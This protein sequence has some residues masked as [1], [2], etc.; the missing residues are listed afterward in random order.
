MCSWRQKIESYCENLACEPTAEV[1]KKRAKHSI[2]VE[3]V[4]GLAEERKLVQLSLN[5]NC[6]PQ[7][8]ARLSRYI[9]TTGKALDQDFIV[10]NTKISFC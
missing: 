4:S 10:S 1:K 5:L 7:V 6:I 2:N 8:F 9:E 3:W